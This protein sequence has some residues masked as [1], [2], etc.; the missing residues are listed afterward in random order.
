MKIMASRFFGFVIM[1]LIVILL[2]VLERWN[3]SHFN[4]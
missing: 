1:G 4:K 3:D 2:V